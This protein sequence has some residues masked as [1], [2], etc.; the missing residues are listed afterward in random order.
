M[1]IRPPS[2]RCR[3]LL[4][5]LM[6]GSVTTACDDGAGREASVVVMAEPVKLGI[7]GLSV[8]HG[9]HLW[10]AASWL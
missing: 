1:R 7:P 9:A 6:C 4:L 5:G 8:P 10:L 2:A 3:D